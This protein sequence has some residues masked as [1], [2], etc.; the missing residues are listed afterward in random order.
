M[1]RNLF[2]SL[3]YTLHPIPYTPIR[4]RVRCPGF[5]IADPGHREDHR[6]RD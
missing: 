5:P 3:P 1:K 2:S 4:Q 6:L